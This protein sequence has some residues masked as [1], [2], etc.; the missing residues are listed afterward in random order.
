MTAQRRCRM[1]SAISIAPSGPDCFASS[2]RT[3][4]DCA[5]DMVQ[6]LFA[7]MAARTEDH[8]AAIAAPA[9]YL[10]E[11]ARNLVRD[12]ARAAA[13]GSE[14][15][16]MPIDEV[17]LCDGDPIAMLEARDR[18]AR[19]G[20]E[21]RARSARV[22]K[23]VKGVWDILT[24]RYFR[25]R[26]QN[27]VEAHFGVQRDRGQRH[28]LVQAQLKERQGLQAR[29]VGTRERHA[30][31]MLGLYRDAARYRQMARDGSPARDSADRARPG[32]RGPELGR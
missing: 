4:Q 17:E 27:E 7:R 13:R 10:R 28:E 24:G 22:R 16:H 11:A 20:H 14:R 8:A 30:R 6:Q 12:Q 21:Q 31:Q 3:P 18:L 32:P 23:G 26:K 5:E 9:A 19:I 15:L 29:I 2:R 1:S 25:V